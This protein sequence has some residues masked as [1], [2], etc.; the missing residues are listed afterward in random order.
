[1]AVCRSI[2]SGVSYAVAAGNESQNACNSSPARVRQSIS[3]GASDR[4]DRGASFSNTGVC[5]AVFA[6]GVD[7]TS[8]RRAG[9]STTLSGTSMASPHAAG[10]AALCLER[11]PGQDPAA[12][13]ACVVDNAS[14]D[15]LSGIGTGSPNRLVYV[16]EP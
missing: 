10:A 5:V 8:A 12:I 16:R 2:A 3:T 15:K 13:K 7:I 14:R 4:T 6:P 9:G 11:H 1:M